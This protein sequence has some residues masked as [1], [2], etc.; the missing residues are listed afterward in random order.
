MFLLDTTEAVTNSGGLVFSPSDLLV[1]AECEYRLLCRLDESLGRRPRSPDVVADQLLTRTAELGLR[2]ERQLLYAYEREFGPFERAS[3]RGVARI[4]P[5]RRMTW[6]DLVD[7][8]ERTFTAIEAGADVVYQASF[9]DGSFHGRADFLV[10]T[11][12]DHA[13]Y[14]VV[15]AK[16]ARRAKVPALLQL[17]A[18][19]DQLLVA[20]FLVAPQVRL[21]LG[22]Q[23]TSHY[24]LT[25][26]LPVYRAWRGRLLAVVDEHLMR[27]GRAPWGG[28]VRLCGRCDDCI[29][30]ATERRDVLLVGGVYESQRARLRAAGIETVED[31][32][33]ATEPPEQMATGMFERLR[34][35]AAL[36]FGA[37]DPDGTVTWLQDGTPARLSWQI[38][39]THPVDALP[40][41]SAGD[42]FFDFEG[43]P[44][45][46]DDRGRTWGI[47]YL[48][49]YVERPEQ[50][51][52]PPPFG[53]FWAHDLAGE[54]EALIGFVD[55]V[56]ARREQFPDL[57]VYHYAAYEKTHLLSIAA[58]HGVYEDEVDRLLSEGV[59]VDLY[60]VVR[61]ALRISAKSY[62]IKKLEP[63][64]MGA[65]LR[66][67]EVQDAATSVVAYAEY[68]DLVV[69]GRQ[70]DAKAALQ[71]IADYNRYDCVSTLRLSQWLRAA[72]DVVSHRSGSAT[73]QRAV[74]APSG[75]AG[76]VVGDPDALAAQIRGVVGEDQAARDPDLQALALLGAAIGYYRREA[77]PFWQQHFSRLSQP[78]DEWL[79][80]R[81]AFL[82]ES[83]RVVIDWAV[84]PGR[85]THSR[86]LELV[87][88]LPEGTDLRVGS[89]PYLIYATPPACARTS[90]D[91]DR[92][93]LPGGSLR[94]LGRCRTPGGDRDVLTVREQLPTGAETF[95]ELP[96][97]LTPA[98]G[99]STR[100]QEMAVEATARAAFCAW[101]EQGELPGDP[102]LDLLR[103]EPPR[104]VGD[105]ADLLGE[106]NA[107][108]AGRPSLQ[109]PIGGDYVEAVTAAV[110]RLDHSYVAVQGP[111]G[112]G[113]THLGSRVVARFVRRGWKVGVVAQSHAVV[114]NMLGAVVAAG[115]SADQVVKKISGDGPSP[116]A[117]C[118]ELDGRKLAL[119]AGEPGPGVIGGTAWDFSAERFPAAALDLLVIDEAGQ[120]SLAN[121]IAV[122]R[123]AKR[124]LLL[125]DP[126]QLPQVAQGTH[127][128]PV[129]TSALGWLMAG[130]DVLPREFGYFLS[131]TW[132]MHPALADAVSVLSYAGAL[133]AQPA[134]ADRR[135]EGVL[136]GIGYVPVAHTGNSVVS[137]EEAAEVVRQVRAHL[138]RHW[139]DGGEPRPLAPT[140]I[141]VVAAYNAQVWAVREALSAAGLADVT[142]GTVDRLQGRQAVVVIVTLAA[143]SVADVRR[144]IGFLLSR[145]RIN[146][147]ISRAQWR[148]VIIRSPELTAFLPHTPRHLAELGAFI[149]ICEGAG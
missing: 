44:L 122:A 14:T 37:A 76:D 60:A 123:S 10:R 52:D 143:S 92:G 130:H 22:T 119:V 73:A 87:G 91:G 56:M 135:L 133:H 142:V 137:T 78:V 65:E 68:C 141:L 148:A 18:Y 3:G 8:R 13:L 47:D 95:A 99:P 89:A 72:A 49:G 66:A 46:S 97:A 16:L 74:A 25:D 104:L 30:A 63:L 144:G 138:G 86:Y 146:V 61:R 107:H 79:G 59:L 85:R 139:T 70:D 94:E 28:G 43:D 20:G 35:N 105:S 128:E 118:P 106:P 58:R 88:R 129:D 112:T 55:Y 147:A 75:S 83:A 53:A 149:G 114:E 21:I 26:L 41:P 19:A 108:P 124:L 145:N 81:N 29:R 6:A 51:D 50:A 54:R 109:P 69:A 80:R 110:R 32:I 120:F 98:P 39:D 64:Y 131:G 117:V 100:P 40:P 90:A 67:G 34:A 57:H 9:F 84:E 12:H 7:A 5:P 82:V 48:F 1:G 15:D 113:K 31:L 140:D 38:I 71:A 115:V 111:P 121:T 125:G 4:D 127:P 101:S 93:W 62:S 103:R 132:R 11:D 23:A 2:H 136:P 102:V 17:A 77:K 134:A 33:A 45:W 96:M 116:T 27:D 42:I 24:R 36:Q 126:Q